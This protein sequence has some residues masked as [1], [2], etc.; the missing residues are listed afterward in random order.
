M[1]QAIGVFSGPV[2][3]SM[4]IRQGYVPS[5][6]TLDEQLAGPLIFSEVQD[7]RDPCAGCAADR[8]ICGGRPSRYQHI[9]VSDI[10][11]LRQRQQCV[12]EEREHEAALL[13]PMPSPWE[14]IR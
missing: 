10:L 13:N 8:A 7:G 9:G 1:S 3:K 6:C 14:E 5:T 2:G 12:D 11:S 4:M